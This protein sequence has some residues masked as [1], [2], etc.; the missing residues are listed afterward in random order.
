MEFYNNETDIDF[1][2]LLTDADITILCFIALNLIEFI[3]VIYITIILYYSFLH[4]L[5]S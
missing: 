3:I 4:V 1:Q 2:T 5:L